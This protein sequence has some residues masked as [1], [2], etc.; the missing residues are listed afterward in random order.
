MPY[1]SG[2]SSNCWDFS[3]SLAVCWRWRSIVM[4]TVQ[5]IASVTELRHYLYYSGMQ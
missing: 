5:N 4:T 2:I 1:D 3:A